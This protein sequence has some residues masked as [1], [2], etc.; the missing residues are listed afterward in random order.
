MRRLGWVAGAAL[1][2]ALA[3][4]G[5]A[6]AKGA[7]VVVVSVDG[8][9][10][11]LVARYVERSIASAER[12]RALAVLLRIDTPGGLDSSMRRII[13]AVLD[14]EV[15]VVCFVGPPGA[16]A[17]S[18]GAFIL[19]GCPIAAMAP[20][21]NVGAAHPVGFQGEVVSEKVT[22]DAAAY[23][24]SL[25]QRWG[26]NAAWAEKA[27][28]DSVSASAGEALR[29]GVIDL[30]APDV[31]SLLRTIDGREVTIAG[32]RAVR[33]HT[34]NAGLVEADMNL[35]ELL[36][37]KA[38]DP[39]IAFLLFVLGL[40]G[41]VFEVTHPGLNLPGVL[42]GLALVTS[43]VILGL[44]PV[45]LAGLILILAALGFFILDLQ[46]VGHG[47]PTAAGIVSLVLGGLF[48]FD[49]SVPTARVSRGLVVGVAIALAFFFG[50]VVR[51]ALRARR[52]P[53][54]AGLEALV[55]TEGTV[56]AEGI[57][58]ARGESWT[59]R[60]QVGPLRPGARV[61]VVAVEGLT[62]V[63]E[64]EPKTEVAT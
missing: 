23:I 32:G 4:A 26:R 19:V 44:L 41:I 51:A 35:I 17:A 30:V 49:A 39:N 58:Q 42:G 1:G 63:V 48:L 52:Q 57:V 7:S 11:P 28:R 15:P 2:F 25:A 37:H 20:G 50:V 56:L 43:L 8:A 29:L 33:L 12:A 45:N 60:S 40:A 62:L 13:K 61:R 27:V 3:L 16:R 14:S 64:P 47:L 36:L 10:D 55:G 38:V 46:V 59:A 18:A 5:P 22:N 6:H 54:G 9:V 31:P 34:A 24:R 21:T 53:P